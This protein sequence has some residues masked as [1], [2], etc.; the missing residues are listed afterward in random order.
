V[1]GSGYGLIHTELANLRL[2]SIVISLYYGDATDTGNTG[3]VERQNGRQQGRKKADRED[4]L[5]E[6][7]ACMKS[8]QDLLERLEARIETNREK[9]REDGV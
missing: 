5:A 8:N 2:H 9:H 1:S 7:S 6:M 3:K 4:M